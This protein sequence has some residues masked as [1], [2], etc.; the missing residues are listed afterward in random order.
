MTEQQ[1][2]DKI[3][4]V[5]AAA[6]PE[7]SISSQVYQLIQPSLVLIQTHTEQGNNSG[8]ALGSGVVISDR[9]EILTSLHVVEGAD[10][11]QVIYADG[12]QAAVGSGILESLQALSDMNPIFPPVD[13]ISGQGL[14]TT[15]IP[16]GEYVPDIIV[17]LSDGASNTGPLP[18]ESA[19]LAAER[20]VRIYTIGYG[21][22]NGSGMNCG[23]QDFNQY[24]SQRNR[25]FGGGGGWRRGIDEETLRGIAEMTGGE[26]YSA[27]SAGELHKVFENLPTHL[28]TRDENMEISV[29][30]A[31]FGMLMAGLAVALSMAWH[32]FP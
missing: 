19:Q 27:T 14:Q 16:T 29:A 31:A 20:G 9:G 32:P 1:L 4:E 26:Y 7:P 12:T 21:T 18:L 28:V 3:L 30:F 15:P 13:E 17:V 6:T 22:N 25:G 5:I 2:N 11:I 8:N 10:A 23:D 24:F